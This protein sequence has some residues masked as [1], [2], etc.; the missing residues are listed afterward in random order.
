MELENLI[1]QALDRDTIAKTVAGILA[2]QIANAIA[3]NTTERPLTR[4]EAAMYLQ[5]SLPTL[6]DWVNRNI[7]KAH[8]IEGRT[9]FLQSELLAAIKKA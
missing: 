5:I 1:L 7:I 2:P 8:K 9:Y 4:E 6:H 3:S